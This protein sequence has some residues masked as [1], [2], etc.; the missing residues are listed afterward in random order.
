MFLRR[1]FV[2]GS[3]LSPRLRYPA[4]LPCGRSLASGPQSLDALT[5]QCPTPSD[6]LRAAPVERTDNFHRHVERLHTAVFKHRI[7]RS[8]VV[9]RFAKVI[10]IPRKSGVDVPQPTAQLLEEVLLSLCPSTRVEDPE[11]FRST[12]RLAVKP[13]REDVIAYALKIFN[14]LLGR[15][16]TTHALSWL[17]AIACMEEFRS[18]DTLPHWHRLLETAA[19]RR[20]KHLIS[21]CWKRIAEVTVG[22]TAETV[23]TVISAL[24]RPSSRTR[25]SIPPFD[26]IQDIIGLVAKYHLSY[27]P[28]IA[29]TIRDAYSLAGSQE[30]A[31]RVEQMYTEAASKSKGTLTRQQMHSLL[32]TRVMAGNDKAAIRLI[33]ELVPL[34]LE[35]EEETLSVLIRRNPTPAN[36]KYWRE[37]IGVRGTARVS[38]RVMEGLL[39][40]RSKEVVPFYLSEL[41]DGTV[42]SPHMLHVAIQSLISTG[43]KIP[44]E[45]SVDQALTLYR[46]YTSQC[47][48]PPDTQDAPEAITVPE[49]AVVEPPLQKTYQLLLR[50][51]T[52]Q[53]HVVKRLPDAVSLVE[54]MQRFHVRVDRHL[55][56]S[57]IVILMRSSSTPSEAFRLYR[58]LA[59]PIA[60]KPQ[61][62]EDDISFNE[63]SYTAIL[64]A[65]CT[66]E[67]WP[68]GIPSA[69]QY[70]EVVA[71]MR[72][73]GLRVTTK[74]YT[75]IIGQLARLVTNL[76]ADDPDSVETRAMIA[77]TLARVHNHLNV[78]SEFTPDP[79]LWNQLMDAYQRA[80]CFPEACRIWQK[81]FSSQM[82]NHASVSIIID[83]C[84]F[85][86][87]Y[88]MAVRIYMTLV[89]QKFPINIRNWNT[90]LECLCRLGKLDEAMKVLCLEMTGRDD[91]IEPD[92]QSVR[93]LLKFAA[94]TNQE[95]EVRS[96][97]KR[98]LPKLYYSLPKDSLGIP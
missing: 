96:R 16:P 7:P 66:L 9:T 32:S 27:D 8:E 28:S 37:V 53:A 67:S 14:R 18:V 62:K 68:N 51:L 34:G 64:H 78:N 76:S 21:K 50:L 39:D 75:I 13:L 52:S 65:F 60:H 41:C 10:S 72:K 71:D 86:E 81:L 12:L 90:F 26:F 85:N 24:F 91:G 38:V 6:T 22:P 11:P 36:L 5:L 57:V 25:D 79:P 88:D 95:M 42:P 69:R 55:T 89:E 33:R 30:V 49:Q 43:L 29:Q 46:E 19:N 74:A 31:H 77:R 98:F 94:K 15:R 61:G 80:G 59:Q 35:P 2:A 63:E 84:A 48:A 3:P 23:K 4:H 44:S 17:W 58:L 92:L 56:V 1:A 82:F 20:E 73:Q 83:A 54:D 97:V 93:I 47:V 40:E 45:Q 87:A 70:F